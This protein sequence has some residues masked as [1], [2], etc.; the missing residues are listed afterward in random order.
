VGCPSR[1]EKKFQFSNRFKP[2]L[3]KEFERRQTP[4]EKVP[5]LKSH[6]PLEWGRQPAFE[7]Y[8]DLNALIVIRDCAESWKKENGVLYPVKK[9]RAGVQFGCLHE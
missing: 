9:R 3:S 7:F 8:I 2:R 4:L 1:I 5:L 6:F